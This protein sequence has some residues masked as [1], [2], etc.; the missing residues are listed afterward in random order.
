M[1]IGLIRVAPKPDEPQRL[2]DHQGIG[3]AHNN[4]ITIDLKVDR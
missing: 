1:D 2:E 4:V 3:L